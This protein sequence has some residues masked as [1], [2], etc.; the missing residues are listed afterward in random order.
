MREFYQHGYQELEQF[1]YEKRM[2]EENRTRQKRTED[3]AADVANNGGE[4]VLRNRMSSAGE[5]NSNNQL[6]SK[7]KKS[8]KSKKKDKKNKRAKEPEH[9][10]RSELPAA[11][12]VDSKG[13]VIDLSGNKDGHGNSDVDIVLN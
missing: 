12:S 2:A 1:R 3:W 7:N 4:N 9:P 8:K 11:N 13:L 5:A 6:Q 10:E